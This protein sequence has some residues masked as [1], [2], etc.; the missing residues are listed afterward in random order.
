MMSLR[1]GDD[2]QWSAYRYRSLFCLSCT[3][4]VKT[5]ENLPPT[6]PEHTVETGHKFRDFVVRITAERHCYIG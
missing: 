6:A 1:P 3:V 5:T 4:W 2:L